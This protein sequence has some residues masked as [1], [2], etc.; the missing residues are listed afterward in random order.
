MEGYRRGIFE[1]LPSVKVVDRLDRAGLP[2]EEE[3][4]SEYLSNLGNSR[5]DL[6]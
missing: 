4:P 3:N 2:A 1:L 6:L 5:L